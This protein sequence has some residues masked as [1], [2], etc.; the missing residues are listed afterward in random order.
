MVYMPKER[1]PRDRS[2]YPE[3]RILLAILASKEPTTAYTLAQEVEK[4][5]PYVHRTVSALIEK[6]LISSES[7]GDSGR[8]KVLLRLTLFGFCQQFRDL[9]FIHVLHTLDP[10]SPYYLPRRKIQIVDN[11]IAIEDY[12]K[13]IGK[14]WGRGKILTPVDHYQAL[15][16]AIENSSKLH[17]I[18]EEITQIRKNFSGI[19]ADFAFNPLLDAIFAA[20]DAFEARDESYRFEQLFFMHIL[21]PEDREVMVSSA[22]GDLPYP[23]SNIVDI[24]SKSDRMQIE[25]WSHINCERV[26]LQ[27]RMK[28]LDKMHKHLF[29]LQEV[30]QQKD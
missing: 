27:D 17:W 29:A 14:Y 19:D 15:L 9:R 22:E 6:G 26:L 20:A 13:V 16:K 30:I 18:F 11:S 10:S 8:R 23:F 7:N 1:Q 2:G 4:S 25:F 5:Y 3:T 28:M 12:R 21:R 24:L